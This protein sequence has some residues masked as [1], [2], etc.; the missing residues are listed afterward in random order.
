[1]NVSIPIIREYKSEETDRLWA[2]RIQQENVFY[3]RINI[4]LLVESMLFV[5]IATG[6]TS[7]NLTEFKVVFQALTI[8]GLVFTL[9]WGYVNWRQKRV[10]E[11]LRPF[12][13]SA[14]A[15]YKE[16][17]EDRKERCKAPFSS[18][19]IMTYLIPLIM[20]IVWSFISFKVFQ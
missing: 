6:L 2:Y 16:I 17:R 13:E 1:M 9:I 3:G 18:W 19:N 12:V 7:A 11:H 4:F 15:E 5:A 8:L 10:Y 20:F 14:C